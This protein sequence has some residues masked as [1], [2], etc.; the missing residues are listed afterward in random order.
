MQKTVCRVEGKSKDDADDIMRI[1]IKKFK[2]SDVSEIRLTFNYHNDL[3]GIP[4]KIL[5]NDWTT[6]KENSVINYLQT[7]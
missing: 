4:I 1:Y 6:A 7:L 5:E 3:L 2:K